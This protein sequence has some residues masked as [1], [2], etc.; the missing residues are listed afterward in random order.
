MTG[1]TPCV[2]I[3]ASTGGPAALLSLIPELPR[4]LP[5]SVLVVQHMP[6]PYTLA[7]ARMLGER[8]SIDGARG[9]RRRP[10]RAR[11]GDRLPGLAATSPWAR[12]AR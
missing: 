1:W 12:A 7:F 5:A 4:E 9:G 3:A 10:A 2:V 6:A 8:A 11:R